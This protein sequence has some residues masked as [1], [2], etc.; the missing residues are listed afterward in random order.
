MGSSCGV[1]ECVLGPVEDSR[2]S[3]NSLDS[4]LKSEFHTGGK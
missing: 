1:F 4:F 2:I 3:M